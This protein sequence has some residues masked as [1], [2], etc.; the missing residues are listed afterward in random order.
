MS[1]VTAEMMG[2]AERAAILTG[3]CA[4]AGLTDCSRAFVTGVTDIGG[5]ERRRRGLNSQAVGVDVEITVQV[6]D[7]DAATALTAKAQQMQQN[8]AA[9]TTQLQAS[10]KEVPAL[11]DAAAALA[12]APAAPAAQDASAT[13]AAL[14]EA[15]V[16]VAAEVVQVEAAVTV[17]QQEEETARIAALGTNCEG[18]W[19]PCTDACT[20]VFTQT[21][22]HLGRGE[23]CPLAPPCA[24]GQDACP[25]G[26][27]LPC[28]G[29]WK[30]PTCQLDCAGLCPP[31]PLRPKLRL[32]RRSHDAGV[33][34]A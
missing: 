27:D 21:Q 8:P 13:V 9:L 25:S 11:T 2:L 20:R 7:A 29:Q 12:V 4:T 30:P 33:T 26:V 32:S 22:A 3:Y 16:E 19:G 31:L 1:G 23:Q 17:L 24:P 15:K 6:A 5:G 14:M 18:T 34:L 10:L 28:V